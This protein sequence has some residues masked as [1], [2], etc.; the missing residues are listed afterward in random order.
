LRMNLLW[1]SYVLN[2]GTDGE[3]TKISY[4]GSGIHVIIKNLGLFGTAIYTLSKRPHKR[5]FF[6]DNDN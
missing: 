3:N 5:E 4:C 6:L 1:A 2:L